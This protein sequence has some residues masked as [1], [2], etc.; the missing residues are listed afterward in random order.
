[1]N[2]E[3]PMRLQDLGEVHYPNAAFEQYQGVGMTSQRTRDRLIQ[4][5]LEEGIRHPS[6]LQVM[7]A[8]PRHLFLDEA[9]A[10]RSYEDT[11]LPI[12]HGQTLS[13]PWVVAKMTE[14]LLSGDTVP[15]TVLEIGTGSGYQTV[16]LAQLVPE[17]Y[18]VE[19]IEP[20]AHKARR[21][22]QKLDINNVHFALSDGRWGW[23]QEK[24]FD[25]I[26]S[27]AAPEA[28]PQSLFEQLKVGG[29]M[30]IPVGPQR[31]VQQLM[32]YQKTLQG[33]ESTVLGSVLF[34]PMLEGIE[35]AGGV[36]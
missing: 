28:V 13:Q 30:V 1:M 27:A 8:T 36:L 26:L 29:R 17:V 25:A 21:T 12:G 22:L 7:R 23:P 18:T 14:F 6:V 32:G 20:L 19:R 31:D 24:Q 35:T 10:S 2:K 4:R 5:L 15:K 9:L 11:A 33:I 3:R 34:V 16:I